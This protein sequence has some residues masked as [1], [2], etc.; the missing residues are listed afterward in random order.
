[1][2]KQEDS[3]QAQKEMHVDTQQKGCEMKSK[4]RRPGERKK[5]RM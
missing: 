5:E 4:E 2:Q 3:R 1:M